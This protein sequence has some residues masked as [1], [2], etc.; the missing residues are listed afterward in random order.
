ME[1]EKRER[2]RRTISCKG[3]GVSI[4]AYRSDAHCPDCQK[5]ANQQK[6]REY[7][8]RQRHPCPG[9][10]KA[11]ARSSIQC[12]SCA[13]RTGAQKRSRENSVHWKGGRAKSKGYVH[14]LVAPEKRKGHRYQPE[15]RV[16]WE[17]AHG[18]LPKGYIVHHK[19]GVK[20]DNR[21]E[22]LEALPRKRHGETHD[23]TLKELRDLRR[24]IAELEAKLDGRNPDP[25]L[26]A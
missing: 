4:L 7:E 2:K 18:P 17:Q 6:V 14:L 10:G 9:C 20:D 11:I 16:L 15:H 8:A 1:E 3:C 25:T 24:R 5:R 26:P 23:Q 22:N 12:R 21:L 13:A 19:N